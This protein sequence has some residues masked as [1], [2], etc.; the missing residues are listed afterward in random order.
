MASDSR[1]IGP[2]A[3]IRA[4]KWRRR[5]P[6]Q[7]ANHGVTHGDKEANRWAH[8]LAKIQF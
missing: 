8:T 6:P 7:E 4:A 1:G 3:L 5:P 2:A